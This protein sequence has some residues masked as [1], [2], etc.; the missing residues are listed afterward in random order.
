MFFPIASVALSLALTVSPLA[1]ANTSAELVPCE[2][3]DSANCFWDAST[4]GNEAGYSFHDIDGVAYYSCEEEDSTNCFF[5]ASSRGDGKG[6]SFTD[7]NGTV[8]Y[9]DTIS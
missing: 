6:R 2:L 5:D 8:I 4:S 3:E 7:V 9:W 1:Y